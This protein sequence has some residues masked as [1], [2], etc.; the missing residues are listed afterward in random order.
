MFEKMLYGGKSLYFRY[1]PPLTDLDAI[2]DDELP[3]APYVGAPKHK[4]SVYFYWWAFLRENEDYMA[5]CDAG[6]SG[7]TQKLY[8][9][10]GDV[11][12]DSF[13]DWWRAGG[14][15]LFCEPP[16]APITTYLSPPT[17]PIAQDRVLLSVPV[18]GD[19]E[20]T[21]AEM[22]KILREAFEYERRRRIREESAVDAFSRANYP[23][24]KKPVLTALHE[25]LVA[26]R[27]RKEN[28]NA[29][30]YEIG[31][32]TGVAQRTAG[33]EGD[34]EHKN[35]VGAS[36]SRSL[37]EAK[38]LIYNVGSGRFP[39]TTQAPKISDKVVSKSAEAS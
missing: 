29:S 25:R 3:N 26:H 33:V 36:V 37:K 10:F 39:D 24:F 8:A 35:I 7:A 34:A 12:G 19:L 5:C 4:R 15:L 30:L 32:I 21:M 14:R 23:V 20:R 17:D 9:D 11:R 27:A 38:A 22:R 6:G 28:P 16:E 13:M 2:S 31:K 18:T 1:A